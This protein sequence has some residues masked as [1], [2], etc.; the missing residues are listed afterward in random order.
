MRKVII[1]E[2]EPMGAPRMT[3]RDKWA[4]RMVVIRYFRFKDLIRETARKKNFKLGKH[5]E[6]T[7]YIQI[8]KSWSKTKT[9]EKNITLHDQKPDLD[10]LLKAFQDAFGEDKHVAS[11]VATKIW[12]DTDP[13]IVASSW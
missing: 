12:T 7:F 5:L 11:V 6:I 13:R 8:P 3:Q 10:N 1:F 2:V 4:Q 9:K